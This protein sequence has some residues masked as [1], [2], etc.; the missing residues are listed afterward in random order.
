MRVT[1]AA[2][3]LPF[4]RS[5]KDYLRRRPFKHIYL[6]IGT[7]VKSLRSFGWAGVGRLQDYGYIICSASINKSYRSLCELA[8]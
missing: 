1:S 4:F 7:L 6:Y 3:L 8:L 5:L 2:V